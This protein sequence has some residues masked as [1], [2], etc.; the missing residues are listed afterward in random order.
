MFE[1][2]VEADD[3]EVE[4]F[5]NGKLID[6]NDGRFLI[7]SQGKKRKLVLKCAQIQDAGDICVKTNT[8]E[9]K[10]KLHVAC[11]L[12]LD[13]KFSKQKIMLFIYFKVKIRFCKDC[14]TA[15]R[16]LKETH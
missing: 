14:Q 15:R 12:N 8:Q 6:G 16:S 10:C 3:A 9:S 13:W 4:W 11:K 2:D 7:V 5:H 1:I